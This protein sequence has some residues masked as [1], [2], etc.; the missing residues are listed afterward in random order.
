MSTV[1][2]Q[3]QDLSGA[4]PIC[5]Q[6]SVPR[7]GLDEHCRPHVYQPFWS[8]RAV[9]GI[10]EESIHPSEQSGFFSVTIGSYAVF[11]Y[12]F[13]HYHLKLSVLSIKKTD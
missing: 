5:S 8:V 11:L 7:A 13:N 3:A 1:Q 9:R 10:R 4:Y 12:I 2:Q 6:A